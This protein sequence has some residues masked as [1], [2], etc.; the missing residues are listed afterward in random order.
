M[1]KA[2]LLTELKTQLVGME[3]VYEHV[4]QIIGAL[5][6]VFGECDR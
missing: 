4:E 6:I 5:D 2:Q 3:R 1:T